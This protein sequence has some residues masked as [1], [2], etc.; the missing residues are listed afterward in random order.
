MRKTDEQRL[1]PDELYRDLMRM[2]KRNQET[3]CLEY[4]YGKSGFGY[5]RMRIGKKLYS[6]HR[7]MAFAVGKLP[8]LELKSQWQ[9]TNNV[10]HLCNNPACCEPS[11]LK[12]GTR[13]ENARHT[14]A[15]GRHPSKPGVVNRGSFA[16][17]GKV[18]VKDILDT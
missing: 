16:A 10:L 15:S 2:C 18:R 13:K 5:G 9:T 4:P 1:Q 7:L 17:R 11:H 8:S 3:G 6:P 12:V 14:V